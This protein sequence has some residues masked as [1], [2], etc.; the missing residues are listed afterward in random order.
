MRLCHREDVHRFLRC[1]ADCDAAGDIVFASFA[2]DG[3]DAAR[4][5]VGGEV[6]ESEVAVG[7]D[8]GKT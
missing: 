5:F 6:G 7:V 4:V 2:E 8:H 3:V 1:R